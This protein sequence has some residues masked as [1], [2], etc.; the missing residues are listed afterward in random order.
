MLAQQP[1]Q[2]VEH[3]HRPGVADV[4]VIVDRRSADIHRHPLRIDR[5]ERALLARQGVVKLQSH[6]G[7]YSGAG[8]AKLL[9]RL[10]RRRW[11]GD[12]DGHDGDP[13]SHRR[14]RRGARARE[15]AGA[16][17][18]RR[19]ADRRHPAARPDRR[20]ADAGLDER[21]GAEEH[22]GERRGLVLQPL[23]SGA[24]AQG[25]DV[26]PGAA[27]GR[28]ARRLRPGRPAGEGAA[29]GRRRRLPRRLPRLLLP[30][31]RGRP[32]GRA[33]QT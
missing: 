4:G 18:Q 24:L 29:A 9:G 11:K 23:A 13:L 1:E 14:Q 21:R 15:R 5:D 6:G 25:R 16:Q 22:P 2:H 33:A 10:L 31:G 32:A 27:G 17:L 26:R 8:R 20:G 3:H 7:A 30:R 19:R 12:I 28:D